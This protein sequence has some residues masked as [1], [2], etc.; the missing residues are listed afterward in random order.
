MQSFEDHKDG[1][2]L[3]EIRKMHNEAVKG[4]DKGLSENGK[5]RA[6]IWAGTSVGIVKKV[7]PAADIVEEVREGAA[8]VLRGLSKSVL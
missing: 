7:Q 5:G 2:D 3:E 1:V 6:A 4:D 8:K